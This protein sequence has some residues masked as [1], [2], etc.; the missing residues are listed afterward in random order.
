MSG[1]VRAP[2]R[3]LG[4]YLRW[5]LIL[6]TA[7]AFVIFTALFTALPGF[8]YRTPRVAGGDFRDVGPE[9]PVRRRAAGQATPEALGG[10]V[11]EARHAVS[12]TLYY[13]T[14][15][16]PY[17]VAPHET[18][19]EDSEDLAG[20]LSE[21]LARLARPPEAEGLLPA[22]PPGTRMLTHFREGDLLLL[23]LSPD[24]QSPTPGGLVSS[25]AALFAT[26]N[27]FTSL[28]GIERVRFLV[29]NQ[30]ALTFRG[31]HAL[32]GEF[33]FFPPVVTAPPPPPSP[34]ASPP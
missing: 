19:V 14:A 15:R 8:G 32:D 2:A 25:H 12:L 31:S 34:P 26:V 17:M 30:E 28:P 5:F 16:E 22:L 21:V 13:P 23:N 20:L 7:S 10:G 29:S 33:R 27:T 1:R 11:R 3:G 9:D 18:L 4:W 24:F 6:L